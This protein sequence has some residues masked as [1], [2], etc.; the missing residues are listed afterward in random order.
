MRESSSQAQL[1]LIEL[2]YLK[3]LWPTFANFRAKCSFDNLGKKTWLI[4]SKIVTMNMCIF[5]EGAIFGHFSVDVFSFVILGLT[6][7]LA[8]T[9]FPERLNRNI[10]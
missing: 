6:P 9:Q 8:N 3:I 2:F 5:L 10:L 7:L 4:L 1:I